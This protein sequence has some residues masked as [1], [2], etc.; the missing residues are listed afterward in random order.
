MN[1]QQETLTNFEGDLMQLANGIIEVSCFLK[2][3]LRLSD[4]NCELT[5]SQAKPSQAN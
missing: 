4:V 2:V 5:P 1:H 3:G